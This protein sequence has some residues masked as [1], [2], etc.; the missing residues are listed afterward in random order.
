MSRSLGSLPPEPA[1]ETVASRLRAVAQF[2]RRALPLCQAHTVE[3]YTRGLWEQ[4]VALSPETVL[5][6]LSGAGLLRQQQRPLEEAAGSG[7]AG[8]WGKCQNPHSGSVSAL[9]V[10]GWALGSLS[11]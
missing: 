8:L 11:G 7:R 3:F 6:V 1:A 5:E 9:L 4:L 10:P 2:L